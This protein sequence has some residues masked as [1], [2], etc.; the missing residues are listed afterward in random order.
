MTISKILTLALL[1]CS[2]LPAEVKYLIPTIDIPMTPNIPTP[3]ERISRTRLS[4]V[5]TPQPEPSSSMLPKKMVSTTVEVESSAAKVLPGRRK[6]KDRQ[7][8]NIRAMM[9]GF[10][11][12]VDPPP[13]CFEVHRFIIA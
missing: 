11:F 13:E 9:R 2:S 12:N 7:K 4:I 6:E 1:A 8:M 3:M 5:N 10:A